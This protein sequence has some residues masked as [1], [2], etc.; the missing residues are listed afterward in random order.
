MMLH[1]ICIYL[2]N[3]CDYEYKIVQRMSE[4]DAHRVLWSALKKKVD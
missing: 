2:D 4:T 1:P 3:L